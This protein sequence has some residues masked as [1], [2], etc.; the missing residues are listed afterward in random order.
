[1]AAVVDS[2]TQLIGG[3]THVTGEHDVG[4]TT[5]ALENGA[6]PSRTCFFDDDVKGRTTVDELR[7]LQ[8]FGAYHDL[9]ALNEG[10]TEVDYYLAVME[11]IDAIQP[12][13]FD[14]IVFDTWSRFAKCLHSYVITHRNE[15]K[16][17]WSKKGT[18]KGAEE[19]VESQWL[20]ARIINKLQSLAPIVVLVTHLK[21]YYAGDTKVPG[22]QIP[23]SSRTLARVPGFRIWLKHNPESVVPIGLVLKRIATRKITP[24]GIRTVSVLPRKI[25]PRAGDES[26]WDTIGY[27]FENPVGLRELTPEEIPDEYELSILNETLT[28]DQKRTLMAMLKAGVVGGEE[29]D[30]SEDENESG[31]EGMELKSI[32]DSLR[33]EGVKVTM[34]KLKEVSGY[35]MDVIRRHWKDVKE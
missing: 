16:E 13:Q 6:M 29:E 15:F 18:I 21:D 12:N 25:V 20:E 35:E 17:H 33:A 30:E 24:R 19:W 8:D 31:L 7:K 10:K 11:L 3:I 27:Y 28:K 34:P 22:K 4:K 23:A 5:F 32:A 26:L 14:A 2:I 9:V 1:M